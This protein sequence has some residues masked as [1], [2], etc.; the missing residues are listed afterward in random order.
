M[1]R[2]I[3]QIIQRLVKEVSKN[4]PKAGLEVSKINGLI[5]HKD[6]ITS[7]MNIRCFI[8]KKIHPLAVSC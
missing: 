8:P 7:R 6:V 2:V 5:S 4:T 3:S 1:F